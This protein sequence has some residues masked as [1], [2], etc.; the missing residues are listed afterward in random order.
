ME[1]IDVLK[2]LEVKNK[3]IYL[4]K[5]SI[6]IENNLE[7]LNLTLDNMFSLLIE[8]MVS[9]IMEI[10]GTIINKE[11]ITLYVKSFIDGYKNKL[12][13]LILSRKKIL[14]EETEN[15]NYK[16]TLIELT[17]DLY[18]K[19]EKYFDDNIDDLYHN[20]SVKYNEYDGNRLN[21]YLLNILKKQ[22][23]MKIKDIFTNTNLILLNNYDE[24]YQKYLDLNERTLKQ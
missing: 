14:L 2:V 3:E 8:N 19:M 23:V 17:S 16:E 5:L 24:S 20:I 11:T 9:K 18:I 13:E 12:Q 7:V 1:N 21:D 6:D 15:N 10:E 22:F 4:H